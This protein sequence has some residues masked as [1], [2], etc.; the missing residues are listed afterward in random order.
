MLQTKQ[1][2]AGQ[3]NRRPVIEPLE[4]RWLLAFEP[5]LLADINEGPGSAFP[6]ALERRYGLTPNDFVAQ[7]YVVAN[8]TALFAAKNQLWKSDGT[9]AGTSL[10][11]DINP[12]LSEFVNV[13]GTVFFTANDGVNG[14]ALWKTDGTTNGT[15]LVKDFVPDVPVHPNHETPIQLINVNGTLFF[16]TNLGFF[17]GSPTFSEL[18]KSDGTTAGTVVVRKMNSLAFRD[19]GRPSSNGR[20]TASVNGALFFASNGNLWKS[21]GTEA[22]TVLVTT[23]VGGVNLL[24]ASNG[25]LFGVGSGTVFVSDGTD[26]GTVIL[27]GINRA[28]ELTD[29][30]GTVFFTGEDSAIGNELWKSD[31]TINGTVLVK[32]IDPNFEGLRPRHFTN[33]NGTLFF[34]AVDDWFS[35]S[36]EVPA[37]TARGFKLY[38]SDGTANGTIPILDVGNHPST[39]PQGAGPR[40]LTNINGKLFFSLNDGVFGCEMWM[41]NG[42]PSGTVRVTDLPVGNSEHTPPDTFIPLPGR[43]LFTA[44]DGVRGRELWSATVSANGVPIALQQSVSTLENTPLPLTLAAIDDDSDPLTYNVISEP[45]NGTLIGAPP[46][47]TYTPA[48]NF[49][50]TDSFTFRANDGT[51]NS[52]LATV[53]ITVGGADPVANDLSA[54]TKEGNPI[55]ITLTASDPRNLPLTYSV[56]SDPLHGTLT[57][58]APNLVYTPEQGYLGADSFTFQAS[59]GLSTSNTGTVS[60][61]MTPNHAPTV[62]DGPVLLAFDTIPV[63][64]EGEDID[65]DALTFTVLSEPDYGVLTG[66][67]PN[68]TYTPVASVN[69][70]VTLTYQ[71]SDGEALS[72]VATITIIVLNV[73]LLVYAE[74]GAQTKEDYAEVIFPGLPD[75]PTNLS[76]TTTNDSQAL[77]AT[78][79]AFDASGTLTFT[80]APNSHGLATVT[81]VLHDNSGAAAPFAPEGEDPPNPDDEDPT[82]TFTIEIVQ[83][84]PWQNDVNPLDSN[85]DEEVSSID[86]LIVINY[87]NG[88][89]PGLVPPESALVYRD[90]SGDNYVSALDILIVFNHLNREAAE[91]DGEGEGADIPRRFQNART[92]SDSNAVI[93]TDLGELITLLAYDGAEQA[94]RRRRLM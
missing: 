2:R 39:G 84:R 70:T 21:D 12:G 8:G 85:N 38:K 35:G 30:N 64:L 9:A 52:N 14:V 5:Q 17:E 46:S 78:Q 72:N 18:W 33:V 24:V 93:N 91:S 80:P 59:N 54:R 19:V 89:G 1:K 7:P 28:R 43:V 6:E 26:Q 57:G 53:S 34:S 11:K 55:S 71:A 27:K 90:T 92:A 65:G 88:F 44:N 75:N 51:Q 40:A 20:L 45:L 67:P 42:T 50:G 83:E 48:S 36:G 56:T 87:L 86:G 73:R 37:G 69:P 25:R 3:R 13:N 81:V 23:K 16:Q 79:P 74:D 4:N 47:L 82:A 63:V 68:L 61:T 77:F 58:A 22:G 29:V 60:L 41:S 62:S 32:D 94:A 66:T 15:V 31:G 10:V 76:F 49:S